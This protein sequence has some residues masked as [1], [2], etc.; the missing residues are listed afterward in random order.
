M[1]TNICLRCKKNILNYGYYLSLDYN[2]ARGIGGATCDESSHSG[3]EHTCLNALLDDDSYWETDEEGPGAWVKVSFPPA[4][5]HALSVKSV[6]NV[7]G[8]VSALTVD[9]DS[10]GSD[11]VDVS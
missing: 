5:V 1:A 8:R 6:C 10:T 9:V 2:V 11:L 7:S 4:N 3:P